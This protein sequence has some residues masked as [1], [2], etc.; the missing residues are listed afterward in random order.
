MFSKAKSTTHPRNL[1]L[2]QPKNPLRRST[3]RQQN[4]STQ[5]QRQNRLHQSCHLIFTSRAI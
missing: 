2:L 3:N 1:T 5:R 4:S